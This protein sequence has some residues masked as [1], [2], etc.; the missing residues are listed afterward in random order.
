MH[1]NPAVAKLDEDTALALAHRIGIAHIFVAG[2]EGA[3]MVAHA[4]VVRSGPRALRFHLARGNR[5]TPRL[6]GATVLLSL[7]GAHGYVTPNWYEA[8]A[9][10]VPTWNYV[11]VEIDGVARALDENGLVAQLDALAEQH[12]PGLSQVPWTRGKMAPPRLA[13]ML[14]A[15]I[16]FEVEVSAVRATVKLSQNKP[17]PDRARVMAGLAAAG[18]AAL[19][20]AMREAV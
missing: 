1:P 19:A 5:A 17:A 13:A 7:V 3:P 6:D 4:P 11:G 16:G 15:I 20:D 12:E 8:P 2:G 18:N 14:K 10:Q 9:D